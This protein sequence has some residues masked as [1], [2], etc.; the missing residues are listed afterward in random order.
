MTYEYTD[1]LYKKY[2][3]LIVRVFNSLNRELQ[4]LNFDELNAGKAYKVVTEKVEKTYKKCYDELIDILILFSLF[5]FGE[6]CDKVVSVKGDKI[7]YYI[8]KKDGFRKEKTFN[9]R[10]F[11]ESYVKSNNPVVKYI[12]DNEYQRKMSRAIES[13][14]TTENKTEMKKQIDIAMRYWNRQ[15]KQ[16]GDNVSSDAYIEG[17]KAMS[18]K[19]VKWITQEDEKVCAACA[20]RDGKIYRID[21]I[22]R[23][24]HY[25]CRCDLVPYVKDSE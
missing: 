20:A 25:N 10:K 22:F 15:A 13:I 8:G 5:Y 3:L 23:P 18:Y 1:K 4:A 11:V 12:F 7:T 21:K 2:S 17:L 16:A 9:A 24:L 14:L 19:Y 6:A